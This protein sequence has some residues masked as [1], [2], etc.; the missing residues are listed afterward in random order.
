MAVYSQFLALPSNSS[1]V[2]SLGAAGLMKVA[3][4]AVVLAIIGGVSSPDALRKWWTDLIMEWIRR[5]FWVNWGS[6][7]GTLCCIWSSE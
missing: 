5:T 2:V 4:F 3:R 1:W 7:D 6:S